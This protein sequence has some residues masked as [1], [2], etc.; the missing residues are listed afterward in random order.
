MRT[1]GCEATFL[2]TVEWNN[3]G[4]HEQLAT[5]MNASNRSTA[6]SMQR[7]VAMATSKPL[8]VQMGIMSKGMCEMLN[9]RVTQA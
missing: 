5:A 3:T 7:L 2:G 9:G 1:R 6:S 8:M 4:R